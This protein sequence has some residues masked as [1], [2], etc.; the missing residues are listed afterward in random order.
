MGGR[1][2]G[3][4]RKEIIIMRTR[5]KWDDVSQ[6]VNQQSVSQSVR[7]EAKTKSIVTVKGIRRKKAGSRSIGLF[8]APSRTTGALDVSCNPSHSARNAP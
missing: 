8:V 4:I 1:G 6:T 7:S 5:T 3:E 2:E